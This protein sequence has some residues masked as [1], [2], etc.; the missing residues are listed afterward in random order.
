MTTSH[1]NYY[2]QV[3]SKQRRA[4]FDFRQ[5]YPPHEAVVDGV[6]WEYID[7]EGHPDALPVL[8]LVG[9]LRVADASFQTTAPLA[10]LHRVIVPTYPDLDTMAATCDGLI[11][12]LDHLGIQ[13]VAVLAGSF[14]GMI[15]QVLV[16]R[17]P[18]RV[19]KL[20]LSSTGMPD[21]EGYRQQMKLL[22]MTPSVLAKRMLPGRMLAIMDVNDEQRDFWRAYLNELFYERLTKE[23]V[24]STYR[25]ILDFTTLNLS[26]ADLANWAGQTLIIQSADDETF[27][28]SERSNITRMYPTAQIHT[29]ASGGHSPAMTQRDAYLALVS[30]FLHAD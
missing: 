17:Y 7:T 13:Q 9:G 26:A 10:Q 12:I 5:H 18:Q 1:Q 14:G 24:L 11:G 6:A 23:E 27:D 22:E 30:A 25:C 2:R 20:I 21:A 16:R 15:A 29:F 4:L 8:L 3:N 28:E 19:R